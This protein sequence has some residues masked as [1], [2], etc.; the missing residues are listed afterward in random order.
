MAG[1]R[2]RPPT[3]PVVLRADR[4]LDVGRARAVEPGVVVV[5]GEQIRDVSPGSFLDGAEV[6]E[7]R[8]RHPAAGSHGHGAQLPHG[9]GG[10]DDDERGPGRSGDEA[11]ARSLRAGARSSPDS[12]RCATS[13]SSYRPA[14]CS[15]TSRSCA[16]STRGG[17]RPAHLPRRARHHALR[18]PP[19]PHDVRGLAPAVMPLTVEEGIADG[20]NQVRQRCGTRSSTAP[21]SS[22]CAP[23]GVMSLT[24]TPGAQHYSDEE[25]RAI[26]DEAHRRACGS[27][28]TRTATRASALRWRRGSTASSTCR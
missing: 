26:V 10:L 19:R 3:H 21:S 9:R 25:L 1:A 15:S 11:A 28:H 16:P 27:R 2:P 14:A 17:P 5:E 24:G 8:R 7:P 4:L 18:R 22:R 6:I 20:V 12:P 23:G 13:G